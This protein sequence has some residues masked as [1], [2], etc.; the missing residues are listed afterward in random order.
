MEDKKIKKMH[1]D[2][3]DN[4]I[5]EIDIKEIKNRLNDFKQYLTNLND[6]RDRWTDFD[7]AVICWLLAHDPYEL[8]FWKRTKF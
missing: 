1:F 5:N 3:E 7:V 8:E 2:Q 6:Y 4:E